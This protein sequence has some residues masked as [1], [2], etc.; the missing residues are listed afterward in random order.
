M[1]LCA[2][3]ALL[4]IEPSIVER[5]SNHGTELSAAE[6]AKLLTVAAP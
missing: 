6:I 3:P 4:Y 1:K 5:N 2:V